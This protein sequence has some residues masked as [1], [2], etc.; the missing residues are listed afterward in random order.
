MITSIRQLA[1]L[2]ILTSDLSRFPIFFHGLFYDWCVQPGLK[3][4]FA[5]VPHFGGIPFGIGSDSIS[6]IWYLPM[7]FIR[8]ARD[9]FCFRL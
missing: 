6:P 7:L 2:A 3:H 1:Q 4:R 8:S 5:E 9:R